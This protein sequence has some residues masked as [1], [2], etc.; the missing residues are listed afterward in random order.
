MS[1]DILTPGGAI[2]DALAHKGWTQHDLALV[3]GKHQPYI[4]EFIQ[5]KRSITPEM[6]VA[7][8][9]ALGNTPEYWLNLDA[10]HRLSLLEPN[11][12]IE[13]RARLFSLAP[14]K[15]MEKRGWIHASES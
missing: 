3:L 6:A 15:D 9:A 5:G 7:L 2:K 14:I 11:T 8:A 10:K 12:E 1:L 4:N 13:R